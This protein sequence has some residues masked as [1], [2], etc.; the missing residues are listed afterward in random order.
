[1]NKFLI[2]NKT[3]TTT[4]AFKS[5]FKNLLEFSCITKDVSQVCN[6][7][8]LTMI[9]SPAN[10]LGRMD[11]GIDQYYKI[12]FPGIEI[13]VK[14]QIKKYDI[15]CDNDY[16]LPIGSGIIV[17]ANKDIKLLCIPTMQVP[18]EIIVTK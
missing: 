14:T 16:I 12:I 1:M 5:V 4:N 15:K 10:S 7:C 17:D 13:K 18:Q 11:G 2:F 8:K 3:D 9:V 6:D